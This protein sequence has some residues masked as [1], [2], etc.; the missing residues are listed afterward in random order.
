MVF[1]CLFHCNPPKSSFLKSRWVHHPLGRNCPLLPAPY[2]LDFGFGRHTEQS[3]QYTK[4]SSP[5]KSGSSSK[6]QPLVV[7]P[8]AMSGAGSHPSS[9]PFCPGWCWLGRQGCR[10]VGGPQ[11]SHQ[12]SIPTSAGKEKQENCVFSFWCRSKTF[13]DLELL[14]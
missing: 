12:S 8:V 10:V 2:F 7:V 14:D 9:I 11:D 1:S 3:E 4:G 6:P 5:P 13:L